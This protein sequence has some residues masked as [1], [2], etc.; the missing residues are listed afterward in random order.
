[1]NCVDGVIDI[2]GGIV[3]E[4]CAG[5]W[6][7]PGTDEPRYTYL[8]NRFCQF[9][10]WDPDESLKKCQASIFKAYL[11]WRC[12]NSRIKKESSIITYWKVLSMFYCDKTATWVDGLVLYDIGNVRVP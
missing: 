3:V 9:M 12:K 6:Y 10:N 4:K 2:K 5:Y 1:M 8:L 7:A 11:R